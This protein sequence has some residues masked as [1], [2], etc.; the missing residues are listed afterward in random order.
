MPEMPDLSDYSNASLRELLE[1]PDR[2]TPESVHAAAKELAT[3][4]AVPRYYTLARTRAGE[5]P[6][7]VTRRLS[8]DPALR[9]RMLFSES[10]LRNYCIAL[11]VVYTTLLPFGVW[12][13]VMLFRRAS[14]YGRY[15]LSSFIPTALS[16]VIQ[17]LMCLFF[18]ALAGNLISRKAD[19]G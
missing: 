15:D 1:D 16:L 7:R 10:R 18:W 2:Y 8:V 4:R 9:I 17:L 13:A 14:A 5:G 19:Q 6:V 12:G 11:A 3:R